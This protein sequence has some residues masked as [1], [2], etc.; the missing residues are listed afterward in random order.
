[1]TKA[2][3]FTP[4]PLDGTYTRTTKQLFNLLGFGLTNTQTFEPAYAN[5]SWSGAFTYAQAIR[6]VDIVSPSLTALQTIRDTTSQ[7]VVRD[8]LCRIYVA[9]PSDVSNIPVS[10]PKFCPPGCAPFTIYREFANA[11]Q[12]FWVPNQPV[13]GGVK[14][15]V[16]S[17]D[18]SQLDESSLAITDY[19]NWSMTMLLT[20]N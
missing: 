2:V 18:G 20:E 3:A 7:Q 6:Y 1:L 8:S 13:A 10:D 14:F 11:K 17:D 16:Y 12:I 15:T 5:I 19:T 9:N 4:M